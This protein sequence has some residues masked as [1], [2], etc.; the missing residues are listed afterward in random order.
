MYHS[1]FYDVLYHLNALPGWR[2]ILAFA[3]PDLHMK[4]IEIIL[5]G[6]ALLIDA[7]SYAPS[8]VKFL[9]QF[10]RKVQKHTTDQNQYLSLLFGSFLTACADLPEDAFLNK[11]SKRFN[12]A[13]FEAAFAAVSREAFAAKRPLNGRIPGD[14]LRR[15]ESDYEFLGAM[16]EG[17][18]QTRNVNNRLERARVILGAL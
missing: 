2:R 14:Q 15:L 8:M 9:N 16:V 10:S 11:K 7:S 1:A 12:V 6:F 18:T 17:T 5:R 13:L 4:D 3:E